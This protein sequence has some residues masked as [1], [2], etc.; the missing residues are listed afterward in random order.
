MLACPECRIPLVRARVGSGLQDICPRCGGRGLTL[1]VLR[2]T[3]DP[4][5]VRGLWSSARAEGTPPGC[6]CPVC[7]RPTRSVQLDGVPPLDVCVPCAFVWLD[8]KDS[9]SGFRAPA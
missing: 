6:L 1:G 9:P 7:V 5:V 8:A 4:S 2:R 3:A